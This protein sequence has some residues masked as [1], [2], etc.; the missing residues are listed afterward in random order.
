VP[1]KA[2]VEHPQEELYPNEGLDFETFLWARGMYMSRGCPMA[3]AH[4]DGDA[5]C[6]HGLLSRSGRPLACLVPFFDLLNHSSTAS[7]TTASASALSPPS[8]EGGDGADARTGVSWDTD[9]DPSSLIFRC[10]GS[11]SGGVLPEGGEVLNTYGSCK[12]N[13]ELL[14][15]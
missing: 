2:T 13:E 5:G 7:A 14:M 8:A 10:C 3:L 1:T 6:P 11:P 12:S 4:N 9:T 15:G